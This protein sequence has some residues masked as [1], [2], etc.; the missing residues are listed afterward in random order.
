MRKPRKPRINLLTIAAGDVKVSW[1]PDDEKDVER[2]AG[3]INDMIEQGYDLIVQG[4]DGQWKRA[5]FFDARQQQY[6]FNDG[7]VADA[8]ESEVT[9]SPPTARGP[10]P[11][12]H[13]G[14]SAAS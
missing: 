3:I 7:S 1:N 6:R 5:T 9:A 2:A 11:E 4:K 10:L 14:V 13:V 8:A 12:N